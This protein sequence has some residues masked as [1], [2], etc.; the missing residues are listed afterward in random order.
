MKKR[1]SK[2]KYSPFAFDGS[3]YTVTGKIFDLAA[4]SVYWLV[5]CIPLVTAGASFSALYAA[6]TKSILDDQGSVSS[7]FWRAYRRDLKAA[8]PVWL[9]YAAAIFVMLLNFGIIRENATGFV[10]LFFQVLYSMLVLFL[11]TAACYV[12]PLLS[13]FDMPWGWYVKLSVYMT[14]RY[15]PKSL[16]LLAVFALSYLLIWKQLAFVLIVPAIGTLVSS[17]L[18]EPLL[19]RH[20][21]KENPDEEDVIA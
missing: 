20:M 17:Y 10:G 11:L 13:R 16:L 6:V 19:E 3:F 21:P 5:G 7:V 4:V 12:F 9:I 2:R 1:E 8:L 18:L 15:L 14:V